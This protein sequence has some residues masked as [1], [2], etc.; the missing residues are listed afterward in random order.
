MNFLLSKKYLSANFLDAEVDL[1]SGKSTYINR[2]RRIPVEL[3]RVLSLGN[4][5]ANGHVLILSS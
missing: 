1:L 2:C 4:P 5:G 3:T